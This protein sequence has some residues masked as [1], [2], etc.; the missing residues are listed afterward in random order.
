MKRK[1][2]KRTEFSPA[3]VK[4]LEA[5][6]AECDF[7]R[8]AK[9]DE[10]ATALGVPLRSIT[11]WFQNKRAKLRKEKKRMDLMELAA[12]TGVVSNEKL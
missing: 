4:V 1:E 6:F 2:K 9:K 5:A 7:A 10:L 3:D 11:V 8:G 12:K